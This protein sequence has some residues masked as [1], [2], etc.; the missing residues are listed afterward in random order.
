MIHFLHVDLPRGQ[1]TREI[2]PVPGR[3]QF[4]SNTY[5]LAWFMFATMDF[6]WAVVSQWL[7]IG[8]NCKAAHRACVIFMKATNNADF[9]VE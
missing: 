3:L 6:K 5:V 8:S 9:V 2:V 1:R 7:H 4:I